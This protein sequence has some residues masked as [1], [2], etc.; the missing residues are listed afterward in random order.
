MKGFRGN[1]YLGSEAMKNK[2]KS[3]TRNAFHSTVESLQQELGFN[4]I[5]SS[6]NA[7]NLNPGTDN[8]IQVQKNTFIA[9]SCSDIR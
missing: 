4:Q 6:K 2:A 3:V 8:E 1:F 9:Y 5:T 7:I